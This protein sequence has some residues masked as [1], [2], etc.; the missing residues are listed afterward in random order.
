M[1]ERIIQGSSHRGDEG[2]WHAKVQIGDRYPTHTACGRD[3]A[4][5]TNHLNDW[6]YAAHPEHLI[7]VCPACVTL[8]PPNLRPY[9]GYK[10]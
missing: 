3:L 7:K 8:H 4:E 2:P 5:E 10:T 9:P 6:D 1:T